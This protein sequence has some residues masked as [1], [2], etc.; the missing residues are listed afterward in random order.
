LKLGP[1]PSRFGAESWLRK[2]ARVGGRQ[3][4]TK[5]KRRATWQREDRQVSKTGELITKCAD[6]IR[7]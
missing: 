2:K 5:S 6:R 3:W 4:E 1:H 7:K